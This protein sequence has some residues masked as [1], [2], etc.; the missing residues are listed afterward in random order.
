VKHLIVLVILALILSFLISFKSDNVLAFAKLDLIEKIQDT[1]GNIIS[2]FKRDSENSEIDP[3]N[4]DDLVEVEFLEKDIS[5]MAENYLVGKTYKNYKLDD[6][7][8]KFTGDEIDVTLVSGDIVANSIIRMN[9][10][11]TKAELHNLN[12]AGANGLT[13]IKSFFVKVAFNALQ[14]TLLDSYFQDF[15]HARIESDKIIIYLKKQN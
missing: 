10:R 15:S 12:I 1:K 4:Y 3:T 9:S 13:T 7:K 8:L 11:G 2:K 5:V 14:G 6:I